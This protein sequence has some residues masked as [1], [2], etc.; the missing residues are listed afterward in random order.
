MSNNVFEGFILE[1]KIDKE[2]IDK[3][4]EKIPEQ[5]TEIW[6]QYGFGS[7]LKGYLKLVN[8][9]VFE[10]LLKDVYIRSEVAIPLFATSMGDIIV[11]EKGRYLNLLN[12][13]KGNVNVISAGFNFFLDDLNDNS[14]IVEELEWNP[15]P[16]AVD[17]YGEPDFDECFGYTPLLGLGGPDKVEN[18]KK[19]KLMEHIYLI[20][21]F[22]GPIE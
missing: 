3:Y 10:E 11:W 15:Y 19:V 12:F 22:M 7:I 20:T 6:R 8:P 9:D 4:K 2:V 14:F 16:E 21:Q 5:I 13:R 17:K 18:L 1:E